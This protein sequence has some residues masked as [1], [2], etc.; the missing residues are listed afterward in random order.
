MALTACGSDRAGTSDSPG[1]GQPESYLGLSTPDRGFQIRSLGAD[2]GP[3]EER[4]YCEVARIP[5]APTDVYHVSSLELANA[6]S[7][8]H[9]ALALAA[10]GSQAELALQALGAGTRIECPGPGLAFGEGIELISTIQT[11]YGKAALPEGV[12]REYHGG[13]LIVFDYHYA[14]AGLETVSARSAANFHLVDPAAVEHVAQ[15]FALNDVTIDIPPG[16]TASVTGEC[17]YGTDMM[18]GGLTRHTHRW[19]GEFSVWHSG[20]ARDGQRI[21]T[22][23]DWEHET[24]HTFAEPLL[25]RAGEGFRYQCTYA[26]D[27]ARHLRFGVSVTDEMCMLYGPAWPAHRGEALQGTY[28]NVTWVDQE[29]IGHPATE[30]GGFPEPTPAEAA[31]CTGALGASLDTCASCVCNSCANPGLRCATDADCAPMLACLIVCRDVACAQGCQ[32]L[33]QQHSS[34]AGRFMSA[35]ECVRVECPSCLSTAG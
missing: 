13:D 26:N 3:G 18:V 32:A 24:E 20:G 4:E 30:A 19:A 25:L 28:C 27:T 7:S 6:A 5:G 14:N 15:G 9:L 12:A 1:P 34:G 10:R 2:I 23:L 8:H 29:G 21:W 33:I 17:H 22:S 35:A 11:R 31:T 16:T